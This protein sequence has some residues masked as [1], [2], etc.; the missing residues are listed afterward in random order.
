MTAPVSSR[1]SCT[2]AGTSARP[3]DTVTLPS[4]PGIEQGPG[5]Y[6]TI[7]DRTGAGENGHVIIEINGQFYESGGESGAWGGGGGVEKIGTPQRRP[8]WRRST[9]SCTRPASERGQ[10]RPR[11][12]AEGRDL[13][14]LGA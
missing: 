7:Y 5:Q 2:P 11:T 9:T 14:A 6:V 3:A 10:R 4:Q 13:R 8:T 12:R 1:R